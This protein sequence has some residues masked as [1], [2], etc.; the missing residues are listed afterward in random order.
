MPQR[1]DEPV[2][3]DGLNR[4]DLIREIGD[5]LAT[6]DPPHVFGIHGDWGL[7]K[8]SVLHQT[9]LYLTGTCP[10][11]SD[12]LVEKARNSR[13]LKKTGHY[14]EQL[15]VVWFE[16]WRY[17]NEEAPIVALLQEIR[18]QLAWHVK[19]V[20]S[21]TKLATV[22]ARSALMNLDSITKMIGVQASKV[23]EEGERWERE[24]LAEALPS[25]VL[26]DQLQ[27]AIKNILSPI[28]ESNEQPKRLVVMIDDLDRCNPAGA[29]RL[30]EGLK[31]Y[32]TLPNCVFLLGMNQRIVE[33]AIGNHVQINSTGEAAERE[34]AE[35][36]AAYLEKLCQ[37][38]WRLPMVGDP[39]Q[40]LLHLLPEELKNVRRWLDTAIGDLRCLPPNPRRLKGL[41]N[42]LGRF[43][44][45]LPT[46][47]DPN[48][49]NER[50]KL[51]GE[52]RLM[53]I[54][55]YI[56]Q[57]H[58]DLFRL[59]ESDP[60]VY[61]HLLNWCRGN[62]LPDAQPATALRNFFDRLRP[63]E[64]IIYD[65]AQPVPSE[66]FEPAFPDPMDT[67][68]FWIQ[69]LIHEAAK[70]AAEGV[71]IEVPEGYQPYLHRGLRSNPGENV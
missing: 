6:C 10:I 58:D 49:E 5:E 34:R 57:F 53:L 35:R 42:L 43:A 55:A 60:R 17:Q 65:D 54:V 71:A 21:A 69:P 2:L 19:I 61:D 1:N 44:R 32:L 28:P 63:V 18:S 26:R 33:S 8:T 36:A 38:I 15:I 68:I 48:D 47:V 7:G 56:Y 11:Y 27:D 52:A 22:A 45:Y 13:K 4:W 20:Q 14:G 70:K 67:G 51:V 37:N 12:E 50:V 59:W 46:T 3:L 31:I 9:Q 62:W 40:Y 39:K 30:L 16:A 23:R 25:N 29:Y 64:F 41:A 66:E 24:N